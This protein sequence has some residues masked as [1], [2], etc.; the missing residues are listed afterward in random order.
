MRHLLASRLRSFADN[1]MIDAGILSVRFLVKARPA[2]VHRPGISFNFLKFN[3]AQLP[4]KKIIR[5]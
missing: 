3:N 5:V 4:E 2:V 1:H